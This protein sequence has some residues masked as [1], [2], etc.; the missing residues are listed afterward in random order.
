[1]VR[2]RM[3]TGVE[4]GER[5]LEP[6][7]GM[8]KLAAMISGIPLLRVEPERLLIAQYGLGIAAERNKNRG[9]ATPVE[10]I[11]RLE[12]DQLVG[13]LKRF[14]QPPCLPER[15]AEVCEIIR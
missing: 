11:V 7:R 15:A 4:K 13:H 2:S 6:F 1:M 5:L 8:E 9:E 10:R 3:C 14:V 12:L